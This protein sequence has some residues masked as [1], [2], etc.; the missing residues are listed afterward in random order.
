MTV[1]RV[2]PLPSR[3]FGTLIR[4]LDRVGRSIDR[5]GDQANFFLAA[6]FSLGKAARAYRRETMRLLAE[7][8]MG[9]GLLAVIGGTVVIVSFLTLF[10]GATVAVQGYDSLGDIGVS[11]LTGFLSAYVNIRVVSPVTAGV[12]LAATIGAGTTAQLGA[13]RISEEIDAL[14]VMAIRSMPFLVSTRILAGLI[15]IVPLYALAVT[16]SFLSS[17]VAT[18]H[19]L[20]Q[21]AGVYDHYFYTF[22]IPSDVLWSFVQAIA[23][24]AV[25]M[26]IHSYYGYYAAGGPSGVGIAT[27]RAVRSSLIAVV[28]VTLLISLALYGG[29]R[30]LHLAG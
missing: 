1:D 6:L 10:A 7:I 8:S 19:I 28:T 9:T 21:S 29:A 13:M 24:A 18:V 30:Q 15:A 23:M 20:G 3:R 12:G 5:A 27:G 25:V 26:L 14:E 16:T 11:S 22:L 4:P 17:R 2:P